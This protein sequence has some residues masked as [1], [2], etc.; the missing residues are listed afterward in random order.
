M[1]TEFTKYVGYLIKSQCLD[2]IRRL[3]TWFNMDIDAETLHQHWQGLIYQILDESENGYHGKYCGIQNSDP[4]DFWS[5][6]LRDFPNMDMDLRYLI[7]AALSLPY[8]SADVERS[9]SG[10]G[11][12]RF[13]LFCFP[14][15][16]T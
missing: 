2:E 10:K 9:F 1:S 16:L 13:L 4:A 5:V 11:I 15:F 7:I 8:S 12:P 3:A 6:I 14:Q